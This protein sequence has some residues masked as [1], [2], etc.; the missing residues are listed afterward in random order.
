MAA[1]TEEQSILKDQAA[2]WLKLNFLF[3]NFASSA[4][5]TVMAAL[6]Q[7]HGP[8]WLIWAGQA[9]WYQKPMV[10]LTWLSDLRADSGAA[11]SATLR[12][13]AICV[14]LRWGQRNQFGW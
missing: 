13:A 14:C 7:K 9:S 1:L 4:T 8:P 5:A 2:S 11:W 3:R 10:A 12:I 6:T